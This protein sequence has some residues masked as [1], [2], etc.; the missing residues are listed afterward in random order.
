MNIL[1]QLSYER[2][3]LK[4]GEITPEILEQ[5]Q[6]LSQ[7]IQE[8]KEKNQIKSLTEPRDWEKTEVL[9]NRIITYLLEEKIAYLLEQDRNFYWTTLIG[10]AVTQLEEE[11]ETFVVFAHHNYGAR[12]FLLD[13]EQTGSLQIRSDGR[14]YKNSQKLLKKEN[15]C[16]KRS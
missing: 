13:M 14:V 10:T 5:V 1:E 4:K 11:F 2:M 12:N 6:L 7:N 9:P 15:C 8:F 16:E 3:L